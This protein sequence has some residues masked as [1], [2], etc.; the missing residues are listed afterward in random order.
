MG[1]KK[2]ALTFGH[3]RLK[4]KLIKNSRPKIL[5]NNNENNNNNKIIIIIIIIMIII[6]NNDNDK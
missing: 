1:W 3:K 5:Q 6:N 2:P 4:P